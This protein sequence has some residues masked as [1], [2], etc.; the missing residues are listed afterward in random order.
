MDSRVDRPEPHPVRPELV[1]GQHPTPFTLSLSKG[2]PDFDKLSPNGLLDDFDKL[3]PSGV[4]DDFDRLSPH[5][6]MGHQGL[7]PMNASPSEVLDQHRQ[8]VTDVAMQGRQ[9]AFERQVRHFV[10]DEFCH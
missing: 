3:S 5:G 2:S 8:H 6:V 4:L 9:G 10:N 1:E 7:I